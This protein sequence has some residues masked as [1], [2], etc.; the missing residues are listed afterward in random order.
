MP[1]KSLRL[2]ADIR[3]SAAFVL[4]ACAG[5]S[6]GDYDADE[7]LRLA[8][9]RSFEIIGEALNRLSRIDPITAGQITDCANIIGFRNILA[10]GYDIVD[11]SRVLQVAHRDVP[12]LLREVAALL[13]E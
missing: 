4:D 2:L 8:V 6:V 9:E 12:T 1:P 5:K 13:E 11:H 10:H 7:M 3:H